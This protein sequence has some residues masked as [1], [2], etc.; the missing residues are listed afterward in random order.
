VQMWVDVS[1]RSGLAS[2]EEIAGAK[3]MALSQ[4]A[5]D[6]VEQQ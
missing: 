4:Y 5:P 1:T 6:L 2:D 3:A